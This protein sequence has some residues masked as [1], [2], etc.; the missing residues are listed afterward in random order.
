MNIYAMA[1]GLIILGLPGI[2]YGY[3]LFVAYRREFFADPANTL[4]IEVLARLIGLGGYG[5]FAALAIILGSML[6]AV[7]IMILVVVTFSRIPQLSWL[8]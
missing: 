3:R 4:S 1:F 6:V 8:V 2:W 5:Y 7:G